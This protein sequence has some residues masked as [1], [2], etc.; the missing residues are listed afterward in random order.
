MKITI[1]LNLL[2]AYFMLIFIST[3]WLQSMGF[4][5]TSYGIVLTSLIIIITKLYTSYN[6]STLLHLGNIIVI[7]FTLIFLILLHGF[8]VS[9]SGFEVSFTRLMF[10]SL[11]LLL[12]VIAAFIFSNL[13]KEI[14]SKRFES[15]MWAV[16][17]LMVIFIPLIF[18]RYS[19]LVPIPSEIKGLLAYI[20][21]YSE[22]S[23]YVIA[24]LPIYLY[25][26]IL[27]TYKSRILII[28]VGILFY[29]VLGS[30]TFFIFIIG[31]C[32][33]L[34]LSRPKLFNLALF[35]I[36]IC[37]IV[38]WVGPFGEYNYFQNNGFLNKAGSLLSLL[39]SET[40]PNDSS[41]PY[42]SI[43]TLSF[44]ADWHQASLNFIN[45]NGLG[46]GFQQTGIS[47]D[48][49]YV[50]DIIYSQSGSFGWVIKFETFSVMPKIISEFGIFAFIFLLLFLKCFLVSIVQ[51]KNS[52]MTKI[53]DIDKKMLLINCFI[54]CNA[55]N[56]FIR[57]TGYFTTSSFLLV[58]AFFYLASIKKTNG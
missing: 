30:S 44:I 46:V 21:V 10:S 51:I 58:V 25:R 26:F 19:V 12:L 27:G 20:I 36:T 48:R 8:I 45:T 14:D 40:L 34:I 54:V 50:K 15:V 6:S 38:L 56:L 55:V 32:F 39:L 17:A 3:A 29:L 7:A 37:L 35:I 43:S 1:P 49:S 5:S 4:G 22:P 41:L 13:L 33:L 57:G 28:G 53:I 16:T 24:F 47:D 23:H 31:L 2:F 42:I 52:I 9:F 18:L 11:V